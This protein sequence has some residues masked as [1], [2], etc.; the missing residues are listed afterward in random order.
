[1]IEI[2]VLY[3]FLLVMIAM[4]ISF[5]TDYRKKRAL[6]C[7]PSVSFIVPVY[8][9]EKHIESTIKSIFRSYNGK[10]E[11]IVVNDGSKD[12]TLSLL[13]KI[14]QIYQL[15]IINNKKNI[16]KAASLNRASECAR[17]KILFIVDSDIDLN[18]RAVH[19]LLTRLEN[20]KV[21][22]VCCGY[23]TREKSLFSVMQDIEYKILNFIQI[24]S[25]FI[26]TPS[27]WGGCMAVKTN[28]F[29]KVGKF[30]ANF[31]TEDHNLA[32]KLQKIGYKTEQ[33]VYTIDTTPVSFKVWTKQKIK[34]GAGATQNIIR[35][36]GLMSG[37]PI[38]SLF[39]IV[40]TAVSALALMGI[41]NFLISGSTVSLL[42]GASYTLA[43]LPFVITT[44]S[45]RKFYRVWVILP[46]SL[47]YW[48][49]FVVLSIIGIVKGV[50]KYFTLKEGSRA[51]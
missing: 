39:L 34:W 25:N 15:K 4:A 50:Y 49:V 48:P 2:F 24:S 18:K 13:K 8:N 32:L 30:S 42:A 35:F 12:G 37:N 9:N 19:N 36:P 5:L 21:G 28:L 11:V 23:S 27:F 45:W 33:S 22:A 17:Y 14:S 31:I 43:S 20:R 10:F 40:Y 47:I 6:K 44:L 29:N 7:M 16:G 51:W 26:S 1:M 38:F 46:F 41:I 3:T